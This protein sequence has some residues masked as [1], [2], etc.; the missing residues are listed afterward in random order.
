MCGEIRAAAEGLVP[1]YGE[2]EEMVPRE[3]EILCGM[4]AWVLERK[5]G[6]ER[7]RTEY[8]FEGYVKEGSLVKPCREWERLSKRQVKAPFADVLSRPTVRSS[9]L[10]SLPRGSRV[11]VKAEGEAVRTGWC[12]VC[13]PDGREGYMQMRWLMPLYDGRKMAE[14]RLRVCVME[15]AKSYLGTA[16]RWGGKTPAGIDCSGLTFMS[17]WLYGITIYRNAQIREGFPVRPIPFSQA[18]PG[19]LLFFP[20]HGAML[21]EDGTYLH[22]TGRAGSDGVVI[23]SLRPGDPRY[24]EDLPRTLR[25]AGTIF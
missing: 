7:I 3:D 12:P 23:N 8:G 16:Y 5:P 2:A 17:Y 1:L 13:L 24:R 19:D 21:L 22:S 9:V 4:L 25:T 6:W 11:G 15:M 10:A 20:G 14:D 18:K